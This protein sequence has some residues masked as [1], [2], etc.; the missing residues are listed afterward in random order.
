MDGSDTDLLQVTKGQIPMTINKVFISGNI[1]RDPEKRKAGETHVL[2]FG[3]A[4]NEYRKDTQYTN[5]FDVD[6]FGNQAKNLANLLAKGDK[7]AI[8]GRLHYATWEKD[9]QKRSK[10]SITADRVELFR[11]KVENTDTSDDSD[12]PW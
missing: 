4:V 5:F 11:A 7:V 9:G 1:T 3:V 8:E 12:I 10:V 6:V 2:S